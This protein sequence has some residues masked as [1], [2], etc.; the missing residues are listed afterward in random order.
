LLGAVAINVRTPAGELEAFHGVGP[1]RLVE[2]V[3]NLKLAPGAA[4]LA[5]RLVFPLG[6][7]VR[8]PA[9]ASILAR[10]RNGH[11]SSAE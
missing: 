3:G 10:G 2:A 6:K 5:T 8:T 11:S 7:V 1:G 9:T 4:R